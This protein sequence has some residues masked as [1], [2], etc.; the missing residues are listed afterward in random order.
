MKRQSKLSDANYAIMKIIWEQGEA[1]VNKIHE[2]VKQAR[3]NT[4]KRESIQVQVKRLAKYGWLKRRKEGKTFFY[5]AVS[6]REEA[7]REI[8]ND[9]KDRVFGGSQADLVKCL[10]ENTNI[11]NGELARIRSLLKDFEIEE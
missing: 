6:E 11:T 7:N 5:S 3:G 9:V 1:S 2:A 8:L 4:I 10:F